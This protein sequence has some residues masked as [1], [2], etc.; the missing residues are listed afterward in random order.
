MRLSIADK[1]LGIVR[2]SNWFCTHYVLLQVGH[3]AT[4]VQ[5]GHYPTR[6]LGMP[7]VLWA[8]FVIWH[9]GVSD[10]ATLFSF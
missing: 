4:R 7:V 10:V 6:V 1:Q 8:H 9:N 3:Y 5:V 2:H